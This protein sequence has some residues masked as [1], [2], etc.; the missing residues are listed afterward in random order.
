MATQSYEDLRR[1]G[2]L[3]SDSS[4]LQY[5]IN[6]G[7]VRPHQFCEEFQQ[8]RDLTTC[9]TSKYSDG[10]CWVCPGNLHYRSVR[11][12]SI[13]NNRTLP[14]AVFLNLLWLFCNLVS[15]SD[16]ARILSINFRTVQK[17]YKAIRQ[18]MAE[19]LLVPFRC[20]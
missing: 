6:N 5:C 14:L 1:S 9:S 7:I 17:L 2:V 10:Y 15:V 16:A 4:T 11:S 3:S 19:D 12:N 18:C 20:C 13:L 8:Y